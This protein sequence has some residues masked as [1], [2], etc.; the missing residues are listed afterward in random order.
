MT[1]LATGLFCVGLGAAVFSTTAFGAEPG[2]TAGGFALTPGG[3]ARLEPTRLAAWDSGNVTVG[4]LIGG[5]A[6]PLALGGFLAYS[7]PSFTLGANLRDQGGGRY[8]ADLGASF[9]TGTAASGTVY[10]LNLG[11]DWGR[12]E[13][14]APTLFS[15]NPQA[16]ALWSGRSEAVQDGADMTMSLSLTHSFTPNLALRGI[17]AAQS[18]AEDESLKGRSVGFTIGAGIGFTF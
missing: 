9:T 3:A 11:A 17:A 4:A 13:A 12:A 5:D 6:Q 16:G 7:S 15:P 8:G 1:S 2:G 10:A 14:F 18:T